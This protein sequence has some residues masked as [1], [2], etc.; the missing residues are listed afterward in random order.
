[1]YVR[2][3][4]NI[5][6]LFGFFILFSFSFCGIDKAIKQHPMKKYPETSKDDSSVD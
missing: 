1:M 2:K 6:F 4:L 5:N 3:I